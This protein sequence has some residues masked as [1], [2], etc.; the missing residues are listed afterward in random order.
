MISRAYGGKENRREGLLRASLISRA[1][2]GKGKSIELSIMLRFDK[3]RIRRERL[4]V[5]VCKVECGLISRAYGGKALA[6]LASLERRVDKPRI[7]RESADNDDDFEK[8]FD[9]PRI[10]RERPGGGG[11]KGRPC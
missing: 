4:D 1:Y 2:G 6:A 5:R 7:R 8:A 3:P 10:R 11:C 9:K